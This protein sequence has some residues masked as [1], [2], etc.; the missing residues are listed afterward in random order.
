MDLLRC[1]AVP[2][3]PAS[4][5]FVS[6]SGLLLGLAELGG[7]IGAIPAFFLV[8]WLF[9]Y[10]YTILEHVANGRFDAPVVSLETLSPLEARPWA[11]TILAFCVYAA[12][13][14]IGGP[15]GIDLGI[16]ALLLLPGSVAVLGTSGRII[17]AFNPLT[18]WR[19]V[20]GLG[21]CYLL[22]LAVVGATSTTA[23]LLLRAPLWPALRYAVMELCV[24]STF[25]FIGGAVYMRRRPLGF[26][27]RTC[28]ERK[29]EKDTAERQRQRQLLLDTV[30]QGVNAR[31]SQHASEP[32]KAWLAALD[33]AHAD[34]DAQAIVSTAMQWHNTR[35]ATIVLRCLIGGLVA[36]AR[37]VVAMRALRAIQE[38]QPDF[39]LDTEAPTLALARCAQ[40][41]GQPR[42]ALRILRLYERQFPEPRLSEAAQQLRRDLA[43][44]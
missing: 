1:F 14:W 25:S 17:D 19:M 11:Q 20:R 42:F 34:E 24:L 10:G 3:Y 36:S 27:P 44:R 16:T 43:D 38:Q 13:R 40:M 22:V 28:P 9:K 37:H 8:S 4:L 35:G 6:L 12:I 41:L 31:R 2:F 29:Q 15:W 18:L 5:I 26:E 32:L 23:V 30:Y 7:L 33:D 21:I 39:T